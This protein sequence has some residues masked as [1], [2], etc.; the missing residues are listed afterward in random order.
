MAGASGLGQ[1]MEELGYGSFRKPEFLP[2]SSGKDRGLR[3]L[4]G[5]A[6]DMGTERGV[7]I[8]AQGGFWGEKAGGEG[9]Q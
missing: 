4:P 9:C 2:S 8:C 5:V 7:L 3:C 1:D 6:G